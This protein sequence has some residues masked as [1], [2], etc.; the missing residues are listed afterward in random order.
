[1]HI[2]FCCCLGIFFLFIKRLIY[3][4]FLKNYPYPKPPPPPQKNEREFISPHAK[5]K[6]INIDMSSHHWSVMS[7]LSDIKV[8][9]AHLCIVAQH[10]IYFSFPDHQLELSFSHIMEKF[11]SIFH[12]QCFWAFSF[13]GKYVA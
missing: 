7:G 3:E 9:S 4:Y 2:I 10:L 13:G 12:F 6:K 8:K 5:R 1:M 11:I